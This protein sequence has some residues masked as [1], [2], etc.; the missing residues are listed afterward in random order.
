MMI[1]YIIAI[2]AVIIP[3]FQ[4]LAYS[5]AEGRDKKINRIYYIY[6][7][8]VFGFMFFS[9][10]TNLPENHYLLAQAILTLFIGVGVLLLVFGK[11]IIK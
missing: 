3:L 2:I 10:M 7:I 11:K 9:E 6:A 4:I 8:L 5:K 1:F